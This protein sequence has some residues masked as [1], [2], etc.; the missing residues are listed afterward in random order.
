[1]MSL[2]FSTGSRPSEREGES[3][4]WREEEEEELHPSTGK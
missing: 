3:E 2:E 1:M 4:G